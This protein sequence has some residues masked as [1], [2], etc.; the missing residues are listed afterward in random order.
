[1]ALLDDV[2]IA[3]GGID[4]WR[5][6]HYFTV[7]FSIDGS[8]LASRGSRAELRELAAQGST[9]APS[10]R[11]TGFPATDRRSDYR[12]DSVT[13]EMLDG[14]S[15]ARRDD[16]RS[17]LRERTG[18][19]WDDLDLA[20]FCGILIWSC[21]AAPFLLA[22]PDV[23]VEEIGAWQEHGETWQR[24]KAVFP[25]TAGMLATEQI[26]YFDQ[27]GLQRRTD[28]LALDAD[29]TSIAQYSWAHQAFSDIVVP[30]LHRGLILQPDGTVVRRPSNLDAEIFDLKFD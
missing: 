7:H 28:Y 22:G 18:R 17:A 23:R 6:L 29:H 21:L 19:A 10:L 25:P 9:Q 12:A 3:H 1:V 13:I 4:R 27:H 20:C 14:T 24:L 11:I 15:V 26:F 30:T 5:P 2:L 16:A 8:V